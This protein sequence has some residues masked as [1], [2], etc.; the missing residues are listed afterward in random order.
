MNLWIP[1]TAVVVGGVALAKVPYNKYL[2]WLAPLLGIYLVLI[3][4][5]LGLGAAL[6]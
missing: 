5:M 3:C 4:V 1:T 2:L 6:G